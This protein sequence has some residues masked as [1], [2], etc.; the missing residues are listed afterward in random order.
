M[1]SEKLHKEYWQRPFYYGHIFMYQICFSYIYHLMTISDKLFWILIWQWFQKI[2]KISF[3][4]INHAPSQAFFW[5]IK[6]VLANFVKGHL[7]DISVKLF[8]ILTDPFRDV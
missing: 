8:S 1:V 6:F 2:F 7:G 4:V 5:W 3:A